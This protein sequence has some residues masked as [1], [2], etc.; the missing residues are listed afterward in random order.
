MNKEKALVSEIIIIRVVACLAIV[1]LHSITSSLGKFKDISTVTHDILVALQMTLIFGTPVFIFISEF[2]LSKS[3]KQVNKP[4]FLV[5]IKLLLLP[6]IMM[7]IVYGFLETKSFQINILGVTIL[8]NIFLGDFVGYFI[9][10]IF[11][12][13]FLHY[14]FQKYISKLNALIVLSFSFLINGIYLAFFNFVPPLEAI[15]NSEYIWKRFS[16]LP[17]TGWI[18]YFAIGF[19]SGKFYTLFKTLISKYRFFLFTGTLFSLF[20]VITLQFFG[21]PEKVSSKRVDILVLT[22]FLIPTLFYLS[23]KIKKVPSW[24]FLI[25][26]YSFSIYLLHI[27]L[28]DFFIKLPINHV[29]IYLF[30]NFFVSLA[31]SISIAWIINKF[32][33]GK[34]LVGNI[35][36]IKK[37]EIKQPKYKHLVG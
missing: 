1:F 29:G 37:K 14:F 28:M 21:L 36:D 24:I 17:F 2:L 7:A 27:M 15:P 31:G 5:R 8:K 23:S 26:N 9:I 30:S 6:Y 13:Y 22:T 25:S 35:A 32:P 19:Y 16:W 20:A 33:Y 12:F 3:Q 18:F 10:I 34:Y 11:Q 4:F